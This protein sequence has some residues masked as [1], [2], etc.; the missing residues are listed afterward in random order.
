M[1]NNAKN[2]VFPL[3]ALMLTIGLQILTPFA[4]LAAETSL[5]A[6][7][8][9]AAQ[10]KAGDI[11][12]VNIGIRNNPGIT[13][14]RLYVSYDDKALRLVGRAID[15]GVLG[16]QFHSDKLTSPYTLLWLN[17]TVNEN[18]TVNGDLATLEFEILSDAGSDINL[19]YKFAQY[20]ILN[21]KL[22]SVNFAIENGSVRVGSQTLRDQNMPN[23]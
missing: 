7:Y 9:S 5:P 12:K 8:A 10:G 17:G 20:D 23:K 11:V 15:K 14:M 22:E 1:R 3:V 2:P 4:V 21:V 19:E 6:V 13:S 18:Y 16:A